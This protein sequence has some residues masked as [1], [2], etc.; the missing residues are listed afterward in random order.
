MAGGPSLK[1]SDDLTRH[2]TVVLLD[3]NFLL[4]PFQ[5]R[6]DI[7]EEIK[8]LLNSHVEFVVLPEILGEL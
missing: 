6:I 7:F 2:P 3:T 4:L 5:R 8:R 1:R